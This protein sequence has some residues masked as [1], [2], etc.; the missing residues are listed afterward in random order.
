MIA[1]RRLMLAAPLLLVAPA[2]LAPPALA[3][4]GDPSVP[5]ARLDAALLQAMRMG[6]GTP[7]AQRYQAIAPAVESAFDLPAILAASVGLGW[8]SFSPQQKQALLAVFTRYTIASY[9]ANFDSYEGQR[10]EILP[11]QQRQAGQ[12]V[13]VATQIVPA[14]GEPTRLDYQMR[15]T[16]QG[17]K[18]VDVLADGSIS[19]VAVQRSDF[20]SLVAGG[21]P[22]PLIASLNQKV[23]S[24][25]GG[26]SLP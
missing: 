10:I 2:A 4:G 17:W 5:I 15:R 21:N 3:Q 22:D 16:P 8:S 24:L 6:K 20:R 25:S 26:A 12:D 18:T 7:F 13:I 11:Q 9:A 23:S 1:S 19:R 14:A